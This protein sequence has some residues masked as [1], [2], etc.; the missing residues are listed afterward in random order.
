[1]QSVVAERRL[2]LA[3]SFKTGE[4]IAVLA[5]VAL[6]TVEFSF[7]AVADATAINTRL[8]ILFVV[9]LAA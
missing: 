5:P 7:K 6:A 2:S 8:L 3:R 1:V 9:R 4:K